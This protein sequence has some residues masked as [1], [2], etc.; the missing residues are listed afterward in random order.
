MHSEKQGRKPKKRKTYDLE[1]VDSSSGEQGAKVR[2]S[3]TREYGLQGKVTDRTWNRK[4]LLQTIVL[5]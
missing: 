1:N 5:M 3:R 4:E 2:V